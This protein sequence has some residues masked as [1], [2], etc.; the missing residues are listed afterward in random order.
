MPHTR[1][2]AMFLALW[3]PLTGW[4]GDLGKDLRKAAEK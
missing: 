4:A 1:I 2:I 3:V